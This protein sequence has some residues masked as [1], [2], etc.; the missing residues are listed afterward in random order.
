MQPDGSSG[1]AIYSPDVDPPEEGWVGHR[2]PNSSS[3]TQCE[4]QVLQLPVNLICQ[5][6]VKGAV[7]CNSQ[8]ALH[9]AIS[10][11]Q[12]TSHRSVTHQILQY[13]VTAQGHSLCFKFWWIPSHLEIAA[14][15]R[16]ELL[17]KGACKL[18]LPDDTT[19]SLP[20]YKRIIH[21]AFSLL[22]TA[23]MLS[24]PSVSIQH[25]DHFR[26]TPRHRRH[27]LMVRR[28]NIVSA[29]LQLGYRPL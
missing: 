7:M 5:R 24:A 10:S 11:P 23:W 18:P 6:R 29:R 9:Q 13:L 20:C 19:P 8:P 17:A 26:L 28:H 2:L 22:S 27:G 21:S 15:D 14:N 4:L 16:V 3:S 1:C 12:R 25:Y